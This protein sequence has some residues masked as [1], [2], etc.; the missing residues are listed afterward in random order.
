MLSNL[1]SI[2]SGVEVRSWS[3]YSRIQRSGAC[4]SCGQ[5]EYPRLCLTRMQ[6]LLVNTRSLSTI[7][8]HSSVRAAACSPTLES[9]LCRRTLTWFWAPNPLSTRSKTL[10]SMLATE[11][12]IVIW[13]DLRAGNLANQVWSALLLPMQRAGSMV[14]N[15][16]TK[17][18]YSITDM[19]TRIHGL[20]NS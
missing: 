20:L 16:F 1:T 19:C 11:S 17:E 3:G 18:T 5:K 13:R 15:G 12:L 4:Y 6:A 2:V 14:A 7:C 10:A 8:G 9:F